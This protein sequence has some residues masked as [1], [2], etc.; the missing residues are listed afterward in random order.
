MRPVCVLEGKSQAEKVKNPSVGYTFS[1]P[2]F[3]ARKRQ[4]SQFLP[5]GKD[6]QR[7]AFKLRKFFQ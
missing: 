2:V 3:T 1:K 5:N 7:S 4:R 6:E